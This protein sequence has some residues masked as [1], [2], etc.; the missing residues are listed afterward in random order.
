MGHVVWRPQDFI[1]VAS[2]MEAPVDVIA[3]VNTNVTHIDDPNQQQIMNWCAA[4]RSWWT[5]SAQIRS[6]AEF[7]TALSSILEQVS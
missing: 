3:D 7:N 2:A 4:A 1:G 5:R 6:S